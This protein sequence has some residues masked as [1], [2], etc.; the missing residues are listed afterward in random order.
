MADLQQRLR[1][2]VET[3]RRDLIMAG[4]GTY[5]ASGTGPLGYTFAPILP[6]PVGTLVPGSPDSPDAA[7]ITI[8]YVPATPAQTTTRTDLTSEA[9][10]LKVNLQPGCPLG[11]PLCGFRQGMRILI[12]DAFGDYDVFTITS[13]L[14][15][16]MRVQHRDNRFT[17]PYA[18]GAYITQVVSHTFYLNVSER[19][20]YAYDGY[21]SNL[22]ILDNIVG[23]RFDYFGD[24]VASSIADPFRRARGADDDLRT[25]TAAP[26]G[27]QPGRRLGCGGELHVS[28]LGRRAGEPAGRL[29]RID[30]G[31]VGPY[32]VRAAE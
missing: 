27:R 21:R 14:A 10:E 29:G 2:G 17:T 24:S 15:D 28:A 13:V 18:A 4:A 12:Y 19:R 3:L 30:A 31:R 25:E 32:D 23:L 11:D 9:A 7:A 8:M 26:H 20:L 22:P 5:S 6:Q 1:V 16:G